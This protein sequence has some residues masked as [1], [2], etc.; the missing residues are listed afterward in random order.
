MAFFL[1]GLW[2]FTEELDPEHF[3]DQAQQ[4]PASQNLAYT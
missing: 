4:T 1:A 2:Q 3:R